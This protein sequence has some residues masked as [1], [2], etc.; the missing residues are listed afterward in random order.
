MKT[1]LEA[2]VCFAD[3]VGPEI[4]T[5]KTWLEVVGH[6][7]K[8]ILNVQANCPKE[9]RW[10]HRIAAAINSYPIDLKNYT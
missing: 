3:G 2:K 5:V 7:G 4:G 10:I 9:Q 1:R 8:V 6:N